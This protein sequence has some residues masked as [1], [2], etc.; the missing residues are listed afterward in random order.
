MASLLLFCKRPQL[1]FG[2]QRLASQI[3][4]QNAFEVSTLLFQCALEDLIA[5]NGPK[6][7]SPADEESEVWA[8]ELILEHSIKQ[9]SVISQSNGNMGERI[10]DLDFKIR[11]KGERNI[12]IIGSDCPAMTIEHYSE[13]ENLLS[14]QDIVITPARDGGATLMANSCSWPNLRDLHWS[15]ETFAESLIETSHQAQ[16]S[17]GFTSP[18][19]DID[20]KDDLL[21][22]YEHA[23]NDKRISRINL[24]E[25]IKAHVLS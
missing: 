4:V 25:W 13:A 19:F 9:C 2:K 7:I 16:L 22:F 11:S 24:C 14:S 5:W 15:T 3:G 20:I 21:F 8:N 6:I 17:V 10:E 18:S 1:G 23:K 12:I